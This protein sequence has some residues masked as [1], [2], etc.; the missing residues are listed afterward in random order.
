RQAPARRG[1]RMRRRGCRWQAG[2]RVDMGWFKR[3]KAEGAG[4]P[5]RA[6][7]LPGGR[8]DTNFG[9]PLR[10]GLIVLLVGFGGFAVWAGLA[11]LDAGVTA[12][13]TVQVAGNRK[14][15]QHL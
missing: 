1:W 5:D 4:S 12:D 7:E 11:P 10:W 8:V 6:L 14:S 2:V 15:V 9:G 3:Q 13:A